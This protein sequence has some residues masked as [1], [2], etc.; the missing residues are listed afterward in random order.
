MGYSLKAFLLVKLAH[1]G[2]YFV[3]LTET[4]VN[5]RGIGPVLDDSFELVHLK[6]I[7]LSLDSSNLRF[8]QIFWCVNF[9]EGFLNN[10]G[11][12]KN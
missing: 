3:K 5:L 1:D 11:S 8:F 9:F 2:F 4:Q 7:F 10:L 12:K 6:I